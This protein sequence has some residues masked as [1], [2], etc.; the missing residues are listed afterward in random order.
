[1]AVMLGPVLFG[2]SPKQTQL[3]VFM[4]VSMR[5]KMAARTF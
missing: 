1:M 3:A 5:R 4:I 2:D